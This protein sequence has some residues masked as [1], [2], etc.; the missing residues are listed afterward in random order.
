MKVAPG[1]FIRRPRAR[2]WRPARAAAAGFPLL[3]LSG[4]S[5]LPSSALAQGADGRSA[6]RLADTLS[7]NANVG[8]TVVARPLIGGHTGPPDSVPKRMETLVVGMLDASIPASMDVNLITG[9]DVH[10]IYGTLEA[11]PSTRCMAARIPD[12]PSSVSGRT[13]RGGRRRQC[14]GVGTRSD[15]RRHR[16]GTSPQDSVR[17][18]LST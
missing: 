11:L 16:G 12:T 1:T 17:K 9:D 5:G 4:A 7:R 2:S 13:E 8:S 6:A 3:G 15:R 10:R 14:V 18:R